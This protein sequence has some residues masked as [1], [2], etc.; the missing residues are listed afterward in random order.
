MLQ[1]K[2][3]YVITDNFGL[4]DRIDSI[5]AQKLEI[6]GR[7]PWGFGQI[8]FRGVLG[9]VRKSRGVHFFCLFHVLLHFYVTIFGPYPLPPPPPLCAFMIGGVTNNSF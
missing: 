3:L 2:P 8:L 9:V 5:D 7:G 1:W 4:C 6:Q